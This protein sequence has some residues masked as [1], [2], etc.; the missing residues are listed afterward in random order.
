MK[1]KIINV[2]IEGADSNKIIKPKNKVINMD[3]LE[4]YRKSLKENESDS[5]HFTYEEI[6]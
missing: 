6:E 3:E 2:K 4:D 5:V 1:I